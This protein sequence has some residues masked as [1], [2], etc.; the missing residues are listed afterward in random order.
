M[1]VEPDVQPLDVVRPALL[2]ADRVELQLPFGDAD[3]AQEL[4]VQLDELGIDRG[5]GGTDRLDR[6]LP[7]FAIAAAAGRAVAVH[8]RDG[9]RLD[10]LRLSVEA[11]FHIRPCDRGRAFRPQRQRPVTPVG[12]RVHLLVDDVGRVARRAAEQGGVLEARGLDR[13]PAVEGRELL[14]GL[15]E[16]PPAMIGREDVVR[17][18]RRLEASVT[19]VR[20]SVRNGFR[21]ARRRASWTARVPGTRRL[22]AG[23][24]G[25]HPDRVQQHVPVAARQV[26]AADGAGKEHVAGEEAAVRRGSDR[27]AGECPGTEH[28]RRG[29]PRRRSSRRL[30]ADV[31][32]AAA[33]VDPERAV[34]V[35]RPLEHH[36]LA[37]RRRRP[38]PRCDSARSGD[39]ADVVVVRVRRRSR[40]TSAHRARAGAEPVGSAPGSTRRLRGSVPRGRRSSSSLSGRAVAV[41]GRR[42]RSASVPPPSAPPCSLVRRAALGSDGDRDT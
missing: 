35:L 34:E 38:A 26:G 17:P 33:D 24:V 9:V 27:C 18:P 16:L 5:V 19:E 3:P 29:G 14:H 36:G 4:D 37:V 40:R 11:V 42:H 28:V 13:P 15:D 20:S 21:R 25:E 6:P 7:V 31:G 8:R 30:R 32:A 41:H 39:A 22:S 23:S 2:V 1:G 10:R 12:E